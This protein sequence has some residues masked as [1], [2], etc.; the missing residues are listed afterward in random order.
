MLV[1]NDASKDDTNFLVK[2][3]GTRMVTHVFSPAMKCD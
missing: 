3:R 1:I 2:G